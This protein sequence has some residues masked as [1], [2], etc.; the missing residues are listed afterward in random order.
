MALTVRLGP[1]SERTLDALAKRRRQSRSD[2]VRDALAHFEAIEAGHVAGSKRPYD[3]WL[4]VI[5]AVNCGARDPDR[6]TGEQF[7]EIIRGRSR[8]RRAR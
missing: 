5:G 7:A 4:D 2:V 3:A 1:K 6:T 8:A